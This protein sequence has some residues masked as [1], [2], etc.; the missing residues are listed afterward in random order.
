MGN[1]AVI[2]F[3]G[4]KTAIYL[5]WNGGRESVEAFLR[6]A[7]D[8][9]VRDPVADE[10]GIARLAQIIGNFFCGTDSIGVGD[11]DKLDRDNG[12]NGVFKVGSGFKII[13]REYDRGRDLVDILPEGELPKPE[14]DEFNALRKEVQHGVGVYWNAREINEPL[15]KKKYNEQIKVT[16]KK[17][18]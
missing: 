6:V 7:K 8:L 1:R 5:H 9:G 10:Y 2:E 14:T 4:Q 16:I 13:G 18:A 17:A 12:N 11:S 15:F 3:E